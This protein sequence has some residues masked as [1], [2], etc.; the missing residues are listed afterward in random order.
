MTDQELIEQDIEEYLARHQRKEL[1]R[2][3]TCGSVDDGKSTLIGRLLHDTKLL[4]EDQ[5]AAVARDSKTQGTQ[6]DEID[7]AL[8]VDG[9]QAEREQGITIDVAYRYFSTEKR[10]FIIADTPGHEQYTRNMA[11]GASTCDLAIILIDARKGV[12]QQTRRHSFICALLGIR[13]VVVAVNKMDLVDFDEAVFE[14]IVSDYS[15]FAAKLDLPDV[16]FLPL[17]ALKGDNVVDRSKEMPWFKGAALLDYLESVHIASDRNLTDLR[18]P[19]QWINR[20]NLDFRGFAGTVASGVLRPGDEVVALPS[21]SRSR[22]KAIHTFDGILEEAVPP[23]AITVTLEDEIDVSRGDMLVHPGAL[24]RVERVFEAMVV[25]MSEEPLQPGAEYFFKQTTNMVSGTVSECRYAVDV[26]TLEQQKASKLALNEVGR[27]VIS[28]NRAIPL[29]AYRNNRRT[30]AFIVIDRMTNITVGAGMIVRRN[31]ADER[32]MSFWEADPR[33]DLLQRRTSSVV[34][35]ERNERLG[36]KPATVLL[37]GLVGAGKTTIAYALER[38]LFDAGRAVQV[39]DGENL[40]LGISRDLG[41]SS[42]ERSENL[43]RASEI[44]RLSNHAGLICICSLLAPSRSAR[45]KARDLIGAERFFEV[46]LTAP[47]ELCRERDPAGMYERADSGEIRSF[48][49]VTAPYEAPENPDLE[50]STDQIDVDVCVDRIV[51]MLSQR[52]VIS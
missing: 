10:K 48:P 2:L 31:I 51:R 44:A 50:L 30:G 49:G 26:N 22:V 52:G 6:G 14:N 25:W 19:V 12:L 37:T 27:C 17:S 16:H 21:E 15:E 13:H 8:L 28:L 1:M 33:S 29:D 43:R 20:P 42:N 40:R 32:G 38:R 41:F 23:Q 36:Q 47:I 46:H 39:L 4:Y 24:P 35:E 11:T 34:V 7:L 45:A 3:L 9:L 18:F 5:L